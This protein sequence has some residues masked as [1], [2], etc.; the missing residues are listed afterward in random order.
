MMCKKAKNIV[1]GDCF[2]YDNSLYVAIDDF[3]EGYIWITKPEY[4]NQFGTYSYTSAGALQVGGDINV[5][6]CL[7]ER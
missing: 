1:K 2:E 3:S 6:I 4:Y 5:K 7:F